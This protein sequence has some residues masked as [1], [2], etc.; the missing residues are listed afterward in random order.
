VGV[1]SPV[2]IARQSPTLIFSSRVTFE[3]ISRSPTTTRNGTRAKATQKP[4]KPRVIAIPKV[5]KGLMTSVYQPK[6][7]RP[8]AC[9]GI[10]AKDPRSIANIL[11]AASRREHSGTEAGVRAIDIAR[12]HRNWPS[13]GGED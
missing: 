7:S 10:N 1:D 13:K 4:T 11:A 3:H 8:G 2:R 9:V 6:F 5:K 12:C